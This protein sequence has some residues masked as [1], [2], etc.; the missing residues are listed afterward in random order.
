MR[1]LIGGIA[2]FLGIK[3]GVERVIVNFANEMVQRGHDISIVYCTD[4]KEKVPYP[5]S[6]IVKLINLSNYG[7]PGNELK[8]KKTDCI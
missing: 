1:I 3:G 6:P 8:A 2:Q 7:A 4:I 5:L